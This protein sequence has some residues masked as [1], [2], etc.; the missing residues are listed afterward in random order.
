MVPQLIVPVVNFQSTINGKL[1]RKSLPPIDHLLRQSI[2]AD[3]TSNDSAAS[4]SES[5][6]DLR[7]AWA[8]VLQ[9]DPNSI[10]TTDHF[11]R[12]GGDSI[13]AI[14]LVSKGQQLG[15][16]LTVPLIYQYPELGQLAHY[17]QRTCLNINE[18]HQRQ[19]LGEVPLTPVQHWF[20]KAPLQNPHHFNQ[21]FTLKVKQA[22]ALP[23]AILIEVLVALANH[24]DILRARIQP[25]ASGQDWI[26]TIPTTA[27][28]PDD[29]VVQEAAVAAEDYPDFILQ[30]QASLN[31]AAGP[32]LAAALIHDPTES[33]D[34][35][36]FITIHHSLVDLVAWRVLI[37]DLNTLSFQAWSNQL[38]DYASGLSA[39]IWPN[40]VDSAVTMPELHML[41][42]P[43]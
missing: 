8:Q 13:S 15:F 25:G 20:M 43:P 36:L 5:E 22:S 4:L 12:I 31:L 40:Q 24:H 21:S 34:T 41:L 37:E 9:M 10:S 18:T 26:Q 35:R 1:D 17:A 2:M 32:I 28:L 19:I 23:V 33:A 42:P 39:D 29:F 7:H 3:N 14:L 30:I 11:F 27:A 16:R 6:H 38:V